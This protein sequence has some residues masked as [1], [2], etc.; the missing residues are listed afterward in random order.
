MALFANAINLIDSFNWPF[1]MV[2]VPHM[3]K[4][5]DDNK[6]IL[7]SCVE[8]ENTSNLPLPHAIQKPYS[9]GKDIKI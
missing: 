1:K 3:K 9:K 2:R 4:L 8:P 6:E 7:G 5:T